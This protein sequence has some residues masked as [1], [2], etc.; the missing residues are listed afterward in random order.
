MLNSE[1]PS[2]KVSFEGS[3]EIRDG[4]IFCEVWFGEEKI[5]DNSVPVEKDRSG[6]VNPIMVIHHGLSALKLK[7]ND[8]FEEHYKDRFPEQHSEG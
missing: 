7:L 8:W 6:F 4:K 1:K 2:P 3:A 5:F